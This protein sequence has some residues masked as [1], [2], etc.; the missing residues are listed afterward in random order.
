MEHWYA[1]N[2]QRFIID[3]SY[4]SLLLSICTFKL[5][6]Q[7]V[8][9]YTTPNLKSFAF[10]LYIESTRL[11]LRRLRRRCARSAAAVGVGGGCVTPPPP[12]T[13]ASAAVAALP[14]RHCSGR[15]LRRFHRRRRRDFAAGARV[16]PLPGPGWRMPSDTATFCRTLNTLAIQYLCAAAFQ[17]QFCSR[18]ERIVSL[19]KVY[20]RYIPGIE[21]HFIW[22]VYTR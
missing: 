6:D 13:S 4:C 8:S 2:D 17:S 22:Q 15:R 3:L 5:I 11:S 7:C 18:A 16:W 10:G 1:S 12:P 19:E 20:T 14:R 21:W 9:R